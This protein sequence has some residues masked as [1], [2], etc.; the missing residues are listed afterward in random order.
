MRSSDAYGSLVELGQ[1]FVETREAAARLG[2]STTAAT[3]TLRKLA[4]A[5]VMIPVRRGLWGLDRDADPFAVV[6]Y[7]TAPFPAYVSFWSALAYHDMIE[8][9]PR[10]IH[11]ASLDRAKRIDTPFADYSIHHLAPELFGGFDGAPETGYVATPE[12]ALFDTVYVRAPRGGRAY[13]PEVTLPPGFDVEET[14][15]WLERIPG[16]RMR[17]IVKRRLESAIDQATIRAVPA[18]RS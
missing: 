10:V 6:P 2:T 8:Q 3:K 16:Q 13:L 11:V 15:R 9:I 4:D 12:K 5:G 18:S 1:P 7:L 14:E 17:T